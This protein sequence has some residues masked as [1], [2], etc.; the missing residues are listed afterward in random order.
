V[1]CFEEKSFRHNSYKRG[2]KVRVKLFKDVL[3]AVK[4]GRATCLQ[5]AV[6]IRQNGKA[7]DNLEAED[8]END[9]Y[10]SDDA[11]TVDEDML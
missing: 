6:K 9:D 3:A 2:N 1:V 5:E 11:V 7:E 10:S 4:V 8:L